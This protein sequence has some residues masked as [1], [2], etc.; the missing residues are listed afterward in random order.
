MR[1]SSSLPKI[2]QMQKLTALMFH[3]KAV[4]EEEFLLKQILQSMVKNF[5]TITLDSTISEQYSKYL[6]Q[7]KTILILKVIKDI[8]AGENCQKDSQQTPELRH[9]NQ[10]QVIVLMLTFVSEL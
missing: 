9:L 7:S 4:K 1:E 3:I 6:H 2:F 8:L 10:H 5:T